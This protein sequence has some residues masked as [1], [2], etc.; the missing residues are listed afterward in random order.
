MICV[1][2]ASSAA[3]SATTTS[4]SSVQLE[5]RSVPLCRHACDCSRLLLQLDS[6][7]IL[8]PAMEGLMDEHYLAAAGRYTAA[9]FAIKYLSRHT[10]F[11]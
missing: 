1:F 2:A 10:W 11:A 8:K 9:V 3:R 7:V 4:S 5:G 6:A